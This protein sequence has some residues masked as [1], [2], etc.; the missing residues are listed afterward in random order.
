MA[1]LLGGLGTGR[2]FR[3]RGRRALTEWTIVA[4]LTL[5]LVLGLNSGK[6]ADRTDFA[7]YDALVQ[8]DR[9][10]T[11]DQILIIAID[12][13]SL[14]ELGR[15]P[16]P[17]HYHAQLLEQLSKADP[18]AIGYDVL[19]VENDDEDADLVRAVAQAGNVYLPALIDAP[20]PDGQPWIIHRPVGQLS[21]AA[22]GIGHVNLTIDSD[23]LV[24]RLP[25]FV[26]TGEVAWPHLSLVLARHRSADSGHSHANRAPPLDSLSVVDDEAISFHGGPGSYR[27]LSFVDVL[28]GEVPAD[29]LRGKL[30]LVGATAA[31]MGDRYAT[32]LAP[33]GELMRGVEIQAAML[34]TVL[35]DS[36]PHDLPDWLQILLSLMP[37]AILLAGFLFLRPLNNMMLG[38]GLMALVLVSSA[39]L[40]L[41]AKTWFAPTAAL[42]GLIFAYPMWSW[43]RLVTASA[44]MQSELKTF[45]Q[46]GLISQIPS[47]PLKKDMALAPRGD[48]VSRQ[49]YALRTTLQ[50]L[51]ALERF[52]HEGLRSL[53]DATIIA[54]NDGTIL[55]ANQKAETLFG[56]RVHEGQT[57]EQ[58]FSSLNWPSWRSVIEAEDAEDVSLPDGLLLQPAASRLTDNDDRDSGFI[59]RLADMTQIRAAERQ[60]DNVVQLLTHDLR[61]P[62]ASI[63]TLLD[64]DPHRNDPET[65]RRIGTYARQT[66]ELAEGYVQLAR[67]ESQIVRADTMDL[68]QVAMDAADTLWPQALA[69]GVSLRT[70]EPEDEI[71]FIGDAS[72]M[73]R[74]LVNLMDN[75]LKYGPAG[76]DIDCQISVGRGPKGDRIQILV[77]D[78]GPGLT[79]EAVERLF[80]PFGQGGTEKVGVGLG[81]AFVRTV[82][83]RHG[84][85][86]VYQ[87]MDP[88]AGFVVSLPA[89]DITAL[90]EA[91]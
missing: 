50:S 78:R 75:A 44:Y 81:L 24:R 63:L 71:L 85:N 27:T 59:L 46:A 9:K 73:R 34:Q 39:G 8:V 5:L 11:D 31:G 45:E 69:K 42:A 88:G 91:D 19:F 72:L 22:A 29:F 16:W 84:G 3:L 14:N 87:A 28:R 57:L 40:F 86:V 49:V 6:T 32:P 51:R 54:D 89:P 21:Q 64:A 55:M 68:V 25:L 4:I 38:L 23:G 43:R 66:L 17:R 37:S 20:G 74:M 47:L 67:A 15:W 60:R 56:T 35:E 12:N 90:P 53:P 80:Q 79:A 7:I 62:Q 41:L 13:R 82:A 76:E 65:N 52:T 83:E 61:A 1:G 10:V 36:A 48:V 30:V 26:Y 33:Q 70:P 58:L 18:F 2:D 77:R